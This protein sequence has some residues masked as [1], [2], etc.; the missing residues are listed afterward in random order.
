MRNQSKSEFASAPDSRTRR[1]LHTV[2]E[3]LQDLHARICRM[4]DCS[5][6]HTEAL[7]QLFARAYVH[8]E[9]TSFTPSGLPSPQALA[10]FHEAHAAPPSAD[11][12][13]PAHKD[14]L[15]TLYRHM[16]T[17]EHIR[18]CQT[19]CADMTDGSR[20]SIA[21]AASRILGRVEPIKPTAHGRVVYQHNIYTDEAFLL[22]SRVLPTA[23]ACYSDSFTGVC[24]QVFDGECEY[25][26]LP[27]ENTQDG[28]LIRFYGLIEKYELKIALT[29]K[30]TTSDNRHSTVFGLCRRGL[31]WPETVVR[32]RRFCFEFMFWQESEHLSLS[33]L[34]HAAECASLSPVR[35]DCL[36]RSD[37]EILMGAGY[38]FDLCFE[39]I[40]NESSSSAAPGY[41]LLSFLMYLSVHSPTYLPLGIYQHL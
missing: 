31:V 40:P 28:K 2:T 23:K 25:C 27:L 36:P 12:F 5:H 34:L 39:I 21:S 11:L 35:I 20:Q 38:P 9:D 16:S 6:I 4:L 41:E 30:V 29:C 18:F 19:L 17:S 37:D 15:V 32:D 22:F 14:Q 10:A 8:V 3:N 7:A 26:I 1:D 13:L 24:E 33:R